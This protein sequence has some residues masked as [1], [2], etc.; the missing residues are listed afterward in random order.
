MMAHFFV[1]DTYAHHVLLIHYD[2]A[3]V[4]HYIQEHIICGLKNPKIC[5]MFI[6]FLFFG[7]GASFM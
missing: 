7:G 2:I 3:R 6:L 4:V 1:S 5:L